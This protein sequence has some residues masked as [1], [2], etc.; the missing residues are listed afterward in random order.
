MNDGAA[1][2]QPALGVRLLPASARY[3]SVERSSRVRSALLTYD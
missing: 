1:A 3:L 2:M